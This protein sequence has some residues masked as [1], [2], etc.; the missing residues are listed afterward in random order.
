MNSPKQTVYDEG[1]YEIA[2]QLVE[3]HKQG[4]TKNVID[5]TAILLVMIPTG[6][7]EGDMIQ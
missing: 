3:A 1:K 7:Y 2:N 6:A 4:N 5:L